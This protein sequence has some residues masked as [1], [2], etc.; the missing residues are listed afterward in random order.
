MKSL[1]S[2]IVLFFLMPIFDHTEQ[3]YVPQEGSQKKKSIKPKRMKTGVLYVLIL[4]FIG[5]LALTGWGQVPIDGSAQQPPLPQNLI[6]PSPEAASLGR[7]GEYPMDLY[8]GVQQISIPLYEINLRGFSLP[9]SLDY[10]PSA[11]SVD[12]I[13]SRVGMNWSLN[14]GGVITRSVVDQVDPDV[15]NLPIDKLN[16][17]P[18]YPNSGD[19]V[20]A[21]Q[22]VENATYADLQPDIFHYN[23]AGRSGKFVLDPDGGQPHLMPYAP[24]KMIK[25][26]G[27]YAGFEVYDEQGHH[28]EFTDNELT[29]TET[30]CD[31]INQPILPFDPLMQDYASGNYLTRVT[32][33]N[34]E[35]IIF[36]YANET[37]E[38][39]QSEREE[40]FF[41]S[42]I[43]GSRSCDVLTDRRCRTTLTIRNG[44]R[45]TRI[46]TSSGVTVE[47]IY[48]DADRTDLPGT[49]ALV[50]VEVFDQGQRIKAYTLS[51]SYV[52]AHGYEASMDIEEKALHTRLRL[53][54]VHEAG[55]PPYRFTYNTTQALPPRLSYAKDHWGFSNGRWS[56]TTAIPSDDR[57][58]F[59]GADR[60]VQESYLFSGLLER[61]DYPTA[62]YSQYIYEANKLDTLVE[63]DVVV[64]RRLGQGLLAT[65]D[66]QGAH[67]IE[68]TLTVPDDL[69]FTEPFTF[70]MSGLPE[71]IP[72][73]PT[74]IRP[75]P[76]EEEGGFGQATIWGP[77][78]T[79]LAYLNNNASVSLGYLAP[80]DYRVQFIHGNGLTTTGARVDVYSYYRHITTEMVNKVIHYGNVRLNKIVNVPDIGANTE[81]IFTYEDV[82]G[83]STFQYTDQ[84]LVELPDDDASENR[85][86]SYTKLSSYAIGPSAVYGMARTGYRRVTEQRNSGSGGYTEYHYVSLASE[87]NFGGIGP[88]SYESISWARGILRERRD[89]AKDGNSSRLVTRT[90]YDHEVN[91]T[92]NHRH[93]YA[94]T[95][96]MTDQPNPP[97]IFALFRVERFHHVSAW[98]YLK[99]M[100]VEQHASDGS[101]FLTEV[102]TY[103]YDNP[104]HAQRTRQERTGSNG[105]TYSTTY[106]YPLDY[107]VSDDALD[108]MREGHRLNAPV[109]VITRVDGTVTAA[110]AVRYDLF[111]RVALPA[112]RYRA[113]RAPG[114]GS[115]TPSTDG[116]TF[117]GYRQEVEYLA[118]GPYGTLQEYRSIDGVYTAL[119]WG[120]QD[121]YP[122]AEVRQARYDQVFHTSFEEAGNATG[123]KTGDKSHQGSYTVTTPSAAGSYRVSYWR[124]EGGQWVYYEAPLS[125]T[126]NLEGNIDELR[127]YPVGAHM[128]TYTYQPGFGMTSVT[129]EANQTT[130]YTY[131]PYGRL[132]NVLDLRRDLMT[133]YEYGYKLP[134]N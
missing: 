97:A 45:L 29:T 90:V 118:Y 71:N 104:A 31:G 93:S 110:Q 133:N 58:D 102:T 78:G 106:R 36:S 100:T 33:V 39:I 122:L 88:A 14:A 89:Y 105:K 87:L 114:Q 22:K 84:Y 25:L 67:T 111:D 98:Y 47:F 38:Y 75:D 8:R 124:K 10:Y 69:E 82:D 50:G 119:L 63:E 129:D 59:V 46:T 15:V 16:F 66:G 9:I 24:L 128:R 57:Y 134:E 26:P 28:Y 94:L 13:S 12:A 70:S 121:R 3:V 60:S 20:F 37:Y 7:Y 32:T 115:F 127:V 126:L 19:Y 17:E 56:N 42:P 53:D 18:N 65:E 80:G 101:G 73:G 112:R 5:P 27:R 81:R 55:K 95:I 92:D 6:P 116:F 35:W 51:N 52:E 68:R 108:A 107:T 125:G 86:C 4:L 1:Y 43:T 123:G 85:K 21:L 96:T 62:G 103:H 49:K 109:E 48:P 54:A 130:Y 11:I 41:G 30:Q 40:T 99:E 91:T 117:P 77:D 132:E 2:S 83:V 23:F 79:Q 72:G 113:E 61:I 76:G 120:Y 131:D 74:P 44:K 64:I 34:G